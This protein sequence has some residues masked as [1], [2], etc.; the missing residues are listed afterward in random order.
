MEIGHH[1]EIVDYFLKVSSYSYL[2][3]DI[4]LC[5]HHQVAGDFCLE[6]SVF[7]WIVLDKS[8]LKTYNKQAEKS[9]NTFFV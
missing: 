6:Q 8:S 4:G 7:L 2:E 5:N 3:N 9:E 1:L